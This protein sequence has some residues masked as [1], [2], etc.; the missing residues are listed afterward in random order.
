MEFKDYQKYRWFFTSQ[1]SLVVGGKSGAQNDELLSRLRTTKKDYVIMHTKEPGSPFCA[2]VAPVDSLKQEE[3]EECAVFTGCF[4][5]AWRAGKNEAIIHIFRLSQLSKD[6]SMKSGTWG[7][8]GPVKKVSVPLKL[9]LIK[10]KGVLRAVPEATVK[11]GKLLA[12][13]PGRINKQDM[14]AKIELELDTPYPQEEVLSALP[15]GGFRIL[16]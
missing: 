1:G 13:S 14:P 16:R 12:L 8:L 9:A 11:K 4:S 10:Q 7:V 15:A 2:I 5:R 3:Y 6:S